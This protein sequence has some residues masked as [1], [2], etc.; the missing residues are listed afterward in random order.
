MVYGFRGIV[1]VFDEIDFAAFRGERLAEQDAAVLVAIEDAP[2]LLLTASMF[3]PDLAALEREPDGQAVQLDLPVMASLGEAPYLAMTDDS[4]VIASGTDTGRRIES[5][6][7]ADSADPVPIISLAGDAGRYYTLVGEA[8]SES[9]EEL[10]AETAESIRDSM[11]ALA[12][13]YDRM[14][15][16]VHFTERGV[17]FDVGMTFKD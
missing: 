12:K 10:S 13:V 6:L 9:N 15:L 5:M 2:G 17:E 1:A 3:S 4:M 8:M 7:A 14:Q 16:N 11:E